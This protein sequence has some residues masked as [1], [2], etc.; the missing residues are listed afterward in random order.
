MVSNWLGTVE[1]AAKRLGH[2][3]PK[4]TEGVYRRKAERAKP[5]R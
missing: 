4:I 2:A 3:D 1:A 5:L